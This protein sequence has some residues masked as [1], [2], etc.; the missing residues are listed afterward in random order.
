MTVTATAK[1][2]Y[3]YD[4]YRYHL[5]VKA[6]LKA[7]KAREK[8][9]LAVYRENVDE[10]VNLLRNLIENGYDFYSDLE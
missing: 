9:E 3:R 6:I 1:E 10:A 5:C 4:E 2:A 7:M 8:A